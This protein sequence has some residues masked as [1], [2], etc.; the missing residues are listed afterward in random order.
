MIDVALIGTGYWGPNVANSFVAT[1][2]A[3]VAGLCDLDPARLAAFSQRYPQA[4]AT[5]R[6]ADILEDKSITAVAVA[7]PTNTHFAIAK[8]ALEAGKHVLVEKP[9]TLTSVESLELGAL[10]DKVGRVLMV[11]HIFL[12]NNTIRALK[13]LVD[14]GELGDIHAMSF[15]RTNLGPVRT[16]VN[17]LWDLTSHDIS[18]M[19][20]LMGAEPVSVSAVGQSFLNK[21]V[22]D[23]TFATFTFPN[24]ALAN[25]HASWLNPQ[26]VRTLTITGSQKMAVWNDLELKEPVLVYDKRVDLPSA[27]ELKGDFM[28]YK[29]LC[30]DGGHTSV[31]VKLNRPLQSECEHFLDC[32]TNGTR[33]LTDAA[34]GA[35]VVRALEAATRSIAQGGTP[36]EIR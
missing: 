25:V 31:P 14:K 34:N 10:A 2:K 36:V 4:K 16:D 7:T 24:G 20:Y 28:E 11:G 33:P 26:K 32:I 19:S 3:R 12:Y 13:D 15:V 29:T 9:L 23:V 5:N 21:G 27:Q 8:A 18:I 35:A 17:A 1:E 30:V 6:L 22:E